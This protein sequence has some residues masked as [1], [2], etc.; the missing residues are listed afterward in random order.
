MSEW[1]DFDLAEPD[2]APRPS[3]WRY[4]WWLG[5][6]V[7]GIAGW[8]FA[9]HIAR[10]AVLSRMDRP[11][12]PPQRVHSADRYQRASAIEQDPVNRYLAAAERGMTERE[13]R[14]MVEDFEQLGAKP[15]ENRRGVQKWYLAALCDALKLS[16]EQQ[17][18]A[19]QKLTELGA[20]VE[21]S[22]LKYAPWNLCALTAEQQ[23]LAQR[24]RAGSANA[25]WFR[26]HP[27]ALSEPGSNVFVEIGKR[28]YPGRLLPITD[29]FPLIAA[30]QLKA[31]AENE[32]EEAIHC[33]PAQLRM[34]LLMDPQLWKEL[35]MNLALKE[36]QAFTG[37][38]F[39]AIMSAPEFHD[40][41]DSQRSTAPDAA[42]DPFSAKPSPAGN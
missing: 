18:Q 30:Q 34:A 26:V 36:F 38:D 12:D 15:A 10:P 5:A 33:H 28:P 31:A 25:A 13:I 17:Q 3:P 23:A 19:A 9:Q 7:L 35:S 29:A 22:Q 27:T 37:A 20:A 8:Q 21:I 14:W 4:G 6:L 42:G 1:D 11:L 41:L 32:L 24:M 2:A 16:R 39:G 40:P